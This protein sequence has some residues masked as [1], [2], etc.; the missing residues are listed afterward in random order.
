MK[1]WIKDYSGVAWE[2][3]KTHRSFFTGL[4]IGL[5]VGLVLF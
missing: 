1:Q 3:V 4:G 2:F 5:F